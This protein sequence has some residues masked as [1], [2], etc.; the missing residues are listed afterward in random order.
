MLAQ[1]C[2]RKI[3]GAGESK[4]VSSVT[5]K[6]KLNAKLMSWRT[7][8]SRLRLAILRR[9]NQ[10]GS[11]KRKRQLARIE[12]LEQLIATAEQEQQQLVAVA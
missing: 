6:Q 7:E 3:S 9:P 2:A 1:S 5:T 10:A 12:Q 4:G 8:L 11:S